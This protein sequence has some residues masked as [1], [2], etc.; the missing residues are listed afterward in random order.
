MAKKKYA[1]YA[2]G[3]NINDETI[4][5]GIN[6]GVGFGKSDF[7]R[8][9]GDGYSASSIASF[10]AGWHGKTG[11]KAQTAL[12]DARLT[13][14]QTLLTQQKAPEPVREAPVIPDPKTLTSESSKVGG[15][16]SG[17]KIKRSKA[18]KTNKNT[19]G[20]RSLNRTSR[21][22]SMKISNLNLA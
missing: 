8:A 10:L 1:G 12:Q 5:Q 15:A 4:Y 11:P 22:A 19:K 2:G 6:Y 7:D 18:S 3:V 21:N 16:A 20:T 9:M 13:E 14:M 17:V